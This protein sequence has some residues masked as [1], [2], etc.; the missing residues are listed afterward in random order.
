MCTI[1]K[2]NSRPMITADTVTRSHCHATKLSLILAT[3][4]PIIYCK[5][6]CAVQFRVGKR[7]R[8]DMI[9][10]A[11]SKWAHIT[12][13]QSI[14]HSLRSRRRQNGRDRA[15]TSGDDRYLAG[16]FDSDTRASTDCHAVGAVN[17][18]VTPGGLCTRRGPSRSLSMPPR[19]ASSYRCG[20]ASNN[21]FND[22]L[23]ELKFS[24]G[25]TDAC[26]LWL[27]R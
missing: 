3:S 21:R 17:R 6:F 23:C 16:C 13:V 7:V 10:A 4:W 5:L 14:V 26:A 18:S 15:L 24:A 27:R 25:V 8:W 2:P 20:V 22:S 19:S 1:F 11:S 9:L 12:V